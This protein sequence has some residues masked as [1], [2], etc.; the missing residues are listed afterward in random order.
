MTNAHTPN[1]VLVTGACALVSGATGFLGHRLVATLVERGYR[2]RALAR[3]T[4]DLSRLS[5]L[6]VEIVVGDVGDRASLV[7]AVAG[8]RV[9]FHTAGLVTDWGSVAEFMAVNRDGTANVIAACQTA[10]VARLVHVSSLTVLGLPR[11]GRPVDEQSPYAIAPP[12]FYTQ[13]KMAA[14]Q[15]VRAAHGRYG[16]A[17]TMIRPGVI[18]GAGDT[19]IMPRIVALMRRELMPCLGRGNNLL[20]LSHV[21]NLALGCILA[22]ES[23]AAAGQIYHVTDGELITLRQALDAIADTY[24]VARPRL[25]IPVWTLQTIAALVELAARLRGRSQPPVITRYGVRL[26]A[27]HCH[28]DIGKARREL[29]YA[30]QVTFAEG[31]AKLEGI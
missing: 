17:T 9:V 22:A 11:D 30:S 19:T 13:S 23:E 7:R 6:G 25:H 16:L 1:T 21:D 5:R 14:E 28:Y 31:I 4:S 3:P 15:L 8:Q 27:C 24:H 12:D 29:G 20:G 18:W 26:L 2:V 10:G